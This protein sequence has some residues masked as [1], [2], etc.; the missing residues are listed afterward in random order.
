MLHIEKLKSGTKLPK[1]TVRNQDN[2]L[3]SWVLFTAFAPT[4]FRN[5]CQHLVRE[6]SFCR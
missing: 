1:F 5:G 2:A 3:V 4:V 6:V